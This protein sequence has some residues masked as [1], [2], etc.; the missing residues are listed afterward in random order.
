LLRLFRQWADNAE[1]QERAV[2]LLMERTVSADQIVRL[3]VDLADQTKRSAGQINRLL[4]TMTE[5]V[6]DSAANAA[7]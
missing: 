7:D 1:L 6:E 4:K 3:I 2:A 5:A